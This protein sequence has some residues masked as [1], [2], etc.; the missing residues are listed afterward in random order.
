MNT[1]N[2]VNLAVWHLIDD[3]ENA[4]PNGIYLCKGRFGEQV[5]V[6]KIMVKK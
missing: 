5:I 3:A 6:K 1:G 2:G 4:V